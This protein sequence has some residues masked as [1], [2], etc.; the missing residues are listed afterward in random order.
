MLW[1]RNSNSAPLV[2]CVEPWANEIPMETEKAYLV[3]FDGP[4]GKFPEV[5]W[6]KDRVTLY[7]WSGSV[8]NVLLDDTVVLSCA[9]PVPS[10]PKDCW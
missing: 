1:V 10:V 5:E 3:V 7:G 4:E 8:A 9:T 2:L 6:R